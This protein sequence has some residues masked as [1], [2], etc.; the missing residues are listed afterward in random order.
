MIGGPGIGKDTIL[1]PL[2]HAVGPW[3]FNEVSPQRLLGRF[4][5]YLKSVILRVNEVRDLGEMSRYSFYEHMKT[6]LATP[7]GELPVDEKNLREHMVPNCVSVAATSNHKTDGIYLPADDRRHYVAWS[8]L[9]SEAFDEDYWLKLWRWYEEDGYRHIAAYLATYD[10]SKFDPKAPPPKTDAFWA[11]VDAN[12]APEESELADILDALG[13]PQA[14]CLNQIAEAEG[15]SMEFTEWLREKKN[16]KAISYQLERCGYVPVRKPGRKD[17]FWL[18]NGT[19][20][21]IYAKVELNPRD[22][23]AAAQR[24]SKSEEPQGYMQ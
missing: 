1:E 20:K 22:Q 16:Q 19:R 4:N 24:L 12:R 10:V 9:T 15:A 6:M 11:I 2:K 7:P 21:V 14:T 17:G 18:I 8:S 13:N 3:N 23:I 5:G